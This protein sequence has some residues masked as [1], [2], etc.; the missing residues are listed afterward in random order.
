MDQ[1]VPVQVQPVLTEY[2]S[3]FH[4]QLPDTLGGLYLHGSIALNAYLDGVS[5]I[6]FIAIVNR[7]LNEAEIKIMAKIHQS[8]AGN[9][10]APGMDGCYLLWEDIG[11]KQT[12]TKTCL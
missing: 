10:K 3:R 2:I 7:P 6:D 9:D 8:L 1:R 5:D 4:E 12:E 11:R